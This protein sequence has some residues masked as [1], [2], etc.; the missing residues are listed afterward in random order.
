MQYRP[1]FSSWWCLTCKEF[2]LDDDDIERDGRKKLAEQTENGDDDEVTAPFIPIPD[3]EF[4][5]WLNYLQRLMC[6]LYGIPPD[7]LKS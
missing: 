4:S 1:V 3:L 6:H 2:R 7:V 5:E